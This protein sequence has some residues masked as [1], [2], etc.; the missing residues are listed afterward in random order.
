MKGKVF[1]FDEH[2]AFLFGRC[3][4]CHARI[5][6]DQQVS[7][8][9]FL[10]EA[11]PPQAA[12]RDLGSLNGTLVN[13]VKRGGR[14][15]DETPE[16]GANRQFP[17]VALKD[18]DK[19]RVGRT[20]L[21]VSIKTNPSPP[22]L[23]AGA[24]IVSLSTD[25]LAAVMLGDSTV[26]RGKHQ[27]SLPGYQIVG[28]LGRGGFGAVFKA[29]RIKDGLPV[30]IKTMLPR[31]AVNGAGIARFQK[32]MDIVGRLKHP[33]IVRIFERG[34]REN[35]L[36]FVMEFC[37]GG[38]IGDFMSK[39]G[40]RIE[41]RQA[42]PIMIESLTALS[43]AHQQGYVHRDLK[44]QNILLT[45]SATKISDFGLAKNFEQAGFS[46]LTL[47]GRYA[48]TPYFMPRE[49]ITNFK[50]VKPVSD[51]WSIGATFYNMLTGAFPYTF[52]RNRDPIDTILNDEVV[53]IQN[54][55]RTVPAKLAAVLNKALSIKS[56]DRFQT[57]SEFLAA[58]NSAL[59]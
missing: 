53:P 59:R 14:N 17:E 54:R 48:G 6:N 3:S 1:S 19:I 43:H 42:A 35:T 10:L 32:E 45:A 26:G 52:R 28:E 57:A 40:G 27:V 13:G 25:Q 15:R 49:Q 22:P 12:L 46:G 36:Y 29:K 37:P 18:G 9:H 51:V 21:A 47:T 11:N 24:D 55:E 2:D 34:S 30:A 23:P 58:V 16:Q 5:P 38:S 33:G 56:G 4:D 8:H 44:P 7:R 41:L 31:A 20:T 50:Y 39:R